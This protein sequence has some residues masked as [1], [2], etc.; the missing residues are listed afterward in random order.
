MIKGHTPTTITEKL[1]LLPNTLH[2]SKSG[3]NILIARETYN[4]VDYTMT[5]DNKVHYSIDIYLM[6]VLAKA[7]YSGLVIE[8]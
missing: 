8:N 4:K 1:S 7:L 3:K 5:V 2:L 6:N